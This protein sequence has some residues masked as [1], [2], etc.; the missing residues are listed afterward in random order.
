MS[1]LDDY[2]LDNY[3]LGA[4]RY[5]VGEEITESNL[6]MIQDK[7]NGKLIWS[8]N[9]N[10]NAS[11]IVVDSN[12]NIYCAYGNTEGSTTLRKLDSEGN[13]IWAK[14]DVTQGKGV[15]VDATG[16]VYCAYYNASGKT[17][18]KM[19][20][21]GNEIWSKTDIPYGTGIA[22]DAS[23]SVYCTHDVNNIPVRKLS[24]SGNSSWTNTTINNALNIAVESS[25]IVYVGCKEP[26]GICK[27]NAGNPPVW[28]FQ[29]SS[30]NSGVKLDPS[31]NV[32]FSFRANQSNSSLIK[33]N[34]NGIMI[35]GIG[36]TGLTSATG[37]DVDSDGNVYLCRST[38]STRG[39][40]K[41]DANGREKWSVDNVLY[42]GGIAIDKFRNVSVLETYPIYR[43]KKLD[44]LQYF[45]L[46]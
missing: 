31:G 28:Q 10:A 35:W 17:I 40:M 2:G 16:N 6:E 29:F 8:K 20:S 21:N 45:L 46:K 42:A 33:T 26:Y 4:K 5:R 44:S 24:S 22:V 37:I 32:L 43:I 12:G 7:G 39:A 15:A 13:Q 1:L 18:R 36:G 34:T 25:N 27:L 3:S 23:G 41:F 30:D 19:D 9:D 38:S 11:S 14:S